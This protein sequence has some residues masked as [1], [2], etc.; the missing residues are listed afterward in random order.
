MKK[1]IFISILI[2]SVF[3]GYFLLKPSSTTYTSPNG[4]YTL[5]VKSKKGM[6]DMAMPGGGG[7]Y[8]TVVEIILKDKKGTILGSSEFKQSCGVTLGNVKIKW[9]IENGYVTCALARSF[10]LKTG[11]FQC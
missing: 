9:N 3:G 7:Y 1:K 10:D 2:L 4:Q 8:S 5:V 6:L 11:E